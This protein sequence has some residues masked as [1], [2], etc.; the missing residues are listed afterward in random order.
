M[1]LLRSEN[2]MLKRRTKNSV[3]LEIPIRA[4]PRLRI[5]A[6]RFSTSPRLQFREKRLL[7]AWDNRDQLTMPRRSAVL[8]QSRLRFDRGAN[9][10]TR[11]SGTPRIC[12]KS[13]HICDFE[14]LPEH[15]TSRSHARIHRI[16]LAR[17]ERERE[18]DRGEREQLLT[19]AN[20]S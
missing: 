17:K 10:T 14:R 1:L 7:R 12:G 19:R 13:L 8:E 4:I 3:E 15:L 2:S 11:G 6:S 20:G 16:A 18:K 5:N 9:I